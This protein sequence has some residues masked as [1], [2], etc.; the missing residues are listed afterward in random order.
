MSCA[1]NVENR[2][3]VVCGRLDKIDKCKVSALFDGKAIHHGHFNPYSEPDRTRFAESVSI[4]MSKVDPGG[5]VGHWWTPEGNEQA[6]LLFIGEKVVQAAEAI[7]RDH[8]TLLVP[9]L[10]MADQIEPRPREWLWRHRIVVGGV[11]MLVGLPD[12]GKSLISIDIAARISRGTIWPD[13]DERAAIG[14]IIILSGEDD[15]ETTIIPRLD[16]AQADRSRIALLSSVGYKLATEGDD[17]L[18]RLD[19]DIAQL[20]AAVSRMADCRLII[21][22][23][24]SCYMGGADDHKGAEVRAVLTKLSDLASRR[25]LSVLLLSHPPKQ[26]Y[27]HAVHR[28]SGSQAYGAHARVVWMAT[29]HTV[30][31]DDGKPRERRIMVL[32][33]GNLTNQRTGL[34]YVI[35]CRNSDHTE[36]HIEWSSEPV[37]LTADEALS[38]VRSKP[39]PRA[40]RLGAA[41]EWLNK[42]LAKGPCPATEIE[43]AAEAADHSETAIKRAKK[44]LGVISFRTLSTGPWTWRLP[45]DQGV[46]ESANGYELDHLD[47]LG[48]IPPNHNGFDAAKFPECQVGES[49]RLAE[50]DEI[51][52]VNSELNGT[53]D[54][55]GEP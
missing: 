24:I 2:F 40:T 36:P 39:G 49:D 27:Q 37:E 12:H 18:I 21:I 51:D 29:K 52:A 35:T 31:G 50:T 23:P 33:K 4:K 8:D 44:Q 22:D 19:T 53:A 47:P 41:I 15:P 42:V 32:A 54:D 25:R 26:E 45:E 30:E 55:W 7:D 16:A 3:T 14:G 1:P 5:W 48:G 28:V 9:R 17:R 43:A 38:A 10:V 11:S 6:E 20:E 46:V 13:C 34:E